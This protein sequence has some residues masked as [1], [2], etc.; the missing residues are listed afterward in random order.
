MEIKVLSFKK[1][2]I[3]SIFFVASLLFSH[4]NNAYALNPDIS[5]PLGQIAPFQVPEGITTAII[6]DENIAS[7]VVPPGQN[8]TMLIYTK[9]PGITNIIVFTE[10]TG[11][12]NNFIVEVQDTKRSEQIVTRIK[13]VEVVNGADG[14]LGMDWQD[15]VS[16]QEAPPSAPFKFGLP[17][18]TSVI[19]AKLN[20]IINDRKGKL[21]AQ[22]TIVSLNGKDAKF[23]S[24]GEYPVLI[25]ER[26]RVNIQFKEYGVKLELNAK[27]EGN[28]TILLTIKP[29]VSSVDKTNSVTIVGTGTTGSAIIPAFATRKAE[30]TLTLKDGESIVIAGLLNNSQEYVDSKIPLLGDIPFLGFLFKSR[31]FRDVKTELVFLLTPSILKNTN[32]LTEKNYADEAQKMGK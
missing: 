22:P 27:I 26:D 30:T 10:K 32:T 28:E 13:V 16:F 3:S 15:F 20:T 14:N 21:L 23:L 17:V 19:E 2:L 7:I 4:N 12:P 18:R 31:E 5:I 25:Y 29:E 6:G 1:F 9:S 11:Q 8:K 24:G